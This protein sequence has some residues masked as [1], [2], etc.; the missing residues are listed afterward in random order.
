MPTA[1]EI[2]TIEGEDIFLVARPES[3]SGGVLTRTEISAAS[4]KVYEE[5][6]SAVA[7]SK[8]L[9][10]NADPTVSSYAD[11]MFSALQSDGWW[12]M[13]GGYTFW[14]VIDY[15]D[16]AMEGGKSY[17]I[18]VKLTAGYAATAWPNLDSYGDLMFVWTTTPQAV[19][20]L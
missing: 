16:F 13:Q 14:A 7:Y 8:T 20:S 11:C 1:I 5:G 4:L 18:E 10:L 12:D 2:E 9:T 6:V 19:G 3:P 17:R 15:T